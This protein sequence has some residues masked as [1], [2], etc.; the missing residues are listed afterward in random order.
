MKLID[1]WKRAWRY[2]TTWAW[3]V[4]LA[5]PDLYSMVAGLMTITDLPNEAAWSIRG[6][7]IVGFVARLVKQKRPPV[8]LPE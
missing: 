2:Y 5:F 3:A 1:D 8:D 7:A 6:L 4:V